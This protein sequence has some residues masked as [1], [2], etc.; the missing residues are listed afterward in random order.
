MNRS[1]K[2]VPVLALLIV[3]ATTW[4]IALADPDA[5][6]VTVI[7]YGGAPACELPEGEILVSNSSSDYWYKV[8]VSATLQ[9]QAPGAAY[10]CE[11]PCECDLSGTFEVPAEADRESVKVCGYNVP[12][13]GC[14]DICDNL[15]SQC[16][17][18]DLHHCACPYGTYQVTYYS[19][20]DGAHYYSMPPAYPTPITEKEQ[21][22]DCPDLGPGCW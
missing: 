3:G 12:C 16:P 18:N 13:G 21:N 2:L 5:D 9:N 14:E 17:P 15:P 8:Q 19:P 4:S 1:I 11:Y 22:E 20:D 10:C 6:D 7:A